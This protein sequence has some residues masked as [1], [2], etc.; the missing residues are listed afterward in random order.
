MQLDWLPQIIGYHGLDNCRIMAAYDYQGMSLKIYMSCSTTI[1]E[2]EIGPVLTFSLSPTPRY[3][4]GEIR[5]AAPEQ[6]LPNHYNVIYLYRRR[7]VS[8]AH[9]CQ[10]S[11]YLLRR[12]CY[13]QGDENIMLRKWR[14]Y[15]TS[16]TN[17]ISCIFLTR[18][19]NHPVHRYN[20]NDDYNNNTNTVEYGV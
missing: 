1:H 2:D 9:K 6:P 15:L 13:I 19:D 12:H 20:I 10:T 17:I 16:T 14:R 5:T 7:A 8:W 18:N 3:G 11:L 4:I